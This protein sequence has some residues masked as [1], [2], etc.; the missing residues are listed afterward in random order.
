ML[1]VKNK[2][3][4]KKTAPKKF[5]CTPTLIQGRLYIKKEK[6]NIIFTRCLLA[7]IIIV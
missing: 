2:N 7:P 4:H 3:F 6:K 1:K 5:L